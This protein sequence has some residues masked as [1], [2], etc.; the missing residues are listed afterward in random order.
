MIVSKIM[1]NVATCHGIVRLSAHIFEA[2]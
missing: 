2:A 1:F